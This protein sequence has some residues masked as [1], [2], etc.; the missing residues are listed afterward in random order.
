[1]DTSAKHPVGEKQAPIVSATLAHSSSTNRDGM[2]MLSTATARHCVNDFNLLQECQTVEP[3]KIRDFDGDTVATRVGK[4]SISVSSPDGTVTRLTLF[5]VHYAPDA[6]SNV[7]SVGQLEDD[8]YDLD[9][10]RQYLKY[11][12]IV[13]S[14]IVVQEKMLLLPVLYEERQ[15]GKAKNGKSQELNMQG[16]AKGNEA[17]IEGKSDD[18]GNPKE[19]Q[20]ILPQVS[21]GAKQPTAEKR[22]HLGITD[23]IYEKAAL[24]AE[25]RQD[26]SCF[27][28]YP[29]A[30][31][32]S[33]HPPEISIR[34]LLLYG[35]GMEMKKGQE[36][37][38]LAAEKLFS[39]E[40]KAEFW[41]EVKIVTRTPGLAGY[42]DGRTGWV[43]ASI[44]KI[45]TFSKFG[46]NG[47]VVS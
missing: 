44:L 2:W 32:R 19:A 39:V 13:V 31:R 11:A 6:P 17:H 36:G 37:V 45:G 46:D 26:I 9:I 40:G 28:G 15:A 24:V 38:V 30:C 21:S 18:K 7:L 4:A 23:A 41:V 43:P 47:I 34:Q 5:N 27:N 3:A 20:Q 14:S 10:K 8:G 1:M 29:C 22:A 25:L 35:T 12:D 16:E 33:Y 42:T